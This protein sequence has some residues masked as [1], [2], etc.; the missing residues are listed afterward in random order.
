VSIFIPEAY[1]N[2][3]IPAARRGRDRRIGRIRRIQQQRRLLA[4]AAL[5]A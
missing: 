5:F 2:R 4:E 1:H 3:S